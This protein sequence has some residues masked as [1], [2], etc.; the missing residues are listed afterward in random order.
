MGNKKIGDIITEELNGFDFLGMDQ[1]KEEQNLR[2]VVSGRDFQT[3]FITDVINNF[4]DNTKF[5]DSQT[6]F[7]SV[8]E[9]NALE[10]EGIDVE[11]GVD[12][13]YVF[14]D[15]DLKMSLYFD[16]NDVTTDISKTNDPGN[17][18]N[19]P[20]ISNMY[21]NIKW[22]DI[23][24]KMFDDEGDEINMNWLDSNPKLYEDFVKTF[25]QPLLE[26]DSNM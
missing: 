24:V 1:I 6:I 14:N 26:M 21:E 23:N 18:F 20:D 17:Y 3:K 7:K 4:N 12:F 8:S 11:Y 5:K 2:D 16:G 9:E 15:S 25:I 13:T 19:E 22:D 10:G